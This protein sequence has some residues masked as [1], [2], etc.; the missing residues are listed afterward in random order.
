MRVGRDAS[1]AEA[2]L[3][4]VQAHPGHSLADITLDLIEDRFGTRV[5]HRDSLV[6]QFAHVIRPLDHRVDTIGLSLWHSE[7]GLLAHE[8]P[9]AIARQ[10]ELQMRMITRDVILSAR[11]GRGLDT[12]EREHRIQEYT[13]LSRSRVPRGDLQRSHAEQQRRAAQQRRSRRIAE[14]QGAMWLDSPRQARSD[15][16]DLISRA[17]HELMLVDCYADARD[18]ADFAHFVTTTDVDIRLLTSSRADRSSAEALPVEDVLESFEARGLRRPTIRHMIDR[19]L[20]DRF[21]VV[22]STV[23]LSGNSFGRIGERR[24]MLVRLHDPKI[25]STLVQAFESGAAWPAVS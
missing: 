11:D 23:W 5:V 14:L 20:H 18:L 17:E 13:T 24:S 3:A 15:V 7:R 19:P 1:E 22:D 21:L 16:R 8:E 12:P 4:V 25:H 9:L 2:L 6:G 10:V